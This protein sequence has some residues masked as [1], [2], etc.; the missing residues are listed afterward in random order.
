[1]QRHVEYLEELQ[2]KLH[3]ATL[4]GDEESIP[5]LIA[6][7]NCA[8]QALNSFMGKRSHYEMLKLNHYEDEKYG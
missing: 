3:L 8:Q 5:W 4:H 7:I 1:M 6:Q 2:D